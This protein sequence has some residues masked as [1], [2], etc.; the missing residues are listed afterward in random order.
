[1]DERATLVKSRASSRVRDDVGWTLIGAPL[2]RDSASKNSTN[3]LDKDPEV[4]ILASLEYE[5]VDEDADD[6][7][8]VDETATGDE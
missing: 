3:I 8:P 7:E 5:E 4:P 2:G 1:M 6:G